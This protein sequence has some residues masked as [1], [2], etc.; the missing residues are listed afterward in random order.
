MF[1]S[2][3]ICHTQGMTYTRRQAELCLVMGGYCYMWLYRDMGGYVWLY[4]V[5]GCYR[6]LWMV[7]CGYV[8]LQVA[9]TYIGL[10]EMCM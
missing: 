9:V 4:R 1:G 7:M 3:V 6:G 5:M 10:W 2:T 8:G